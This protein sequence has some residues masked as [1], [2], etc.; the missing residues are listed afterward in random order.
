MT[1]SEIIEHVEKAIGR[2][3]EGR[4]L[5][6]LIE[7]ADAGSYADADVHAVVGDGAGPAPFLAALDQALR[8]HHSDWPPALLAQAR[9]VM[10][11]L[12]ELLNRLRRIQ[13]GRP[14]PSTN[15]RSVLR[16]LERAAMQIEPPASGERT[17]PRCGSSRTEARRTTAFGTNHY[18]RRCEA[19]GHVEEWDEGVSLGEA[20]IEARRK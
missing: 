1:W 17:C 13:S 18:E 8:A 4:A 20:M 16:R 10:L 2:R 9:A 5:V 19:C 11:V 3:A 6:T 12:P 7:R 15:V 14:M